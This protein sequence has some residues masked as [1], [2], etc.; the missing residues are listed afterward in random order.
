MLRATRGRSRR[1]PESK[2]IGRQQT[3]TEYPFL[4]EE[5]V[6][7]AGKRAQNGY[8]STRFG[9]AKSGCRRRIAHP[10]RGK[11]DGSAVEDAGGK[12]LALLGTLKEK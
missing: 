11:M 7:Y 4:Y 6:V 5:S 10:S 3:G 1:N 9:R 2:L 8:F 12:W